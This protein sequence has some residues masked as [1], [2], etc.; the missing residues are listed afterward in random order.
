MTY[1]YESTG[2]ILPCP[3]CGYEREIE[4]PDLE[5]RDGDSPYEQVAKQWSIG[6]GVWQRGRYLSF[7]NR[8][9]TDPTTDEYNGP[10]VDDLKAL[11]QHLSDVLYLFNQSSIPCSDCHETEV[12][13]ANRDDDE[14]ARLRFA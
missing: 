1:T 2:H 3:V 4:P 5:W 7:A 10:T 6:P 11:A 9:L 13:L 12:E 14:I 8:L